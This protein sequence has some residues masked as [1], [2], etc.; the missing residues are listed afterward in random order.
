M[1][2]GTSKYSQLDEARKDTGKLRK[3]VKWQQKHTNR[4]PEQDPVISG[5]RTKN[6]CQWKKPLRES[7]KMWWTIGRRKSLV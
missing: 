6:S 5:N 1:K 3:R 4:Q 2:N 7:Q